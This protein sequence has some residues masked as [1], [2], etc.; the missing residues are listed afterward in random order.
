MKDDI[1]SDMFGD[2]FNGLGKDEASERTVQIDKVASVYTYIR[3]ITSYKLKA[4]KSGGYVIVDIN[5]YIVKEYTNVN[6]AKLEYIKIVIG[7]N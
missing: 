7:I 2:I 4:T 6:D 5:N 1:F 3:S